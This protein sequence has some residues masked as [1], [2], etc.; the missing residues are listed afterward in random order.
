[1]TTRANRGPKQQLLVLGLTV[2]FCAIYLIFGGM[3]G[4]YIPCIFHKI[5]HLYC[6]G[7]GV[8]R[9]FV[10]ILM[11]DFYQALRY[12]PL[13]FIFL[14]FATIY[15]IDNLISKMRGRKSLL[16]RT[17]SWV[18]IL[19][20]IVLVVYGVMRNLPWSNYLAPTKVR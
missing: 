2:A 12:N 1:M 3:T 14:P 9:M 8:T 11:G 7:C 10:A 19:V 6:P 17:P 18:W 20:I 5:T 4:I 13:V 15:L 16:A